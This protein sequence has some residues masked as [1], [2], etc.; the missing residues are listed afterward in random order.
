MIKI[1]GKYWTA[2]RGSLSTFLQYRLNLVLYSIGHAITITALYFLWRAIYAS[3]HALGNYT[4]EQILSYYILIAL[5]RLTINESTGMAFQVTNDVREGKVTP[6]LTRPFS[7]PFSQFVDV[8]AK[9]TLNITVVVPVVI[10]ASFIFGLSAY[11]P[12]GIAIL[13]GAVWSLLALCLYLVMYFLVAIASFWA[14]RAESYIYAV[15]VM[16]NFFNG[17]LIPL[18]AFPQ[19]FITI[20]NYLPFKYLMFLPIQAFLGRPTFTTAN[21]L[22]GLAWLGILSALVIWAWQRGLKNYE[23]QGI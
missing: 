1:K 20:S 19:W 5:L 14:D 9:T 11:L 13:H 10:G 8:L 16:S 23:S 3:G 7:Y 18:D 2:Y 21:V 6:F 4:F 15:I 22:G 12:H 17:S